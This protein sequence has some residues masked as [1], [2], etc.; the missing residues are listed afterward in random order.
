MIDD[1]RCARAFSTTAPV[2]DITLRLFRT[3]I[4][5]L[6]ASNTIIIRSTMNKPSIKKKNRPN[7]AIIYTPA[8]FYKR[9]LNEI[10][11]KVTGFENYFKTQNPMFKM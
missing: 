8:E 11:K 2:R 7:F 10:A 1:S 6:I 9:R 5:F 3:V 4:Y